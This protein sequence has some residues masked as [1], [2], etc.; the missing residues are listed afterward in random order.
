MRELKIELTPDNFKVWSEYCAQSTPGMNNLIDS[1]LESKKPFTT[2]LNDSVHSS[3]FGAGQ[4]E[5]VD[6]MRAEMVGILEQLGEDIEGVQEDFSSYGNLL[7]MSAVELDNNPGIQ[8]IKDLVEKLSN[9]T[10]STQKVTEDMGKSMGKL[11]EE[12]QRLSRELEEV[13]EEASKDPLTGL[14]N[15][16]SFDKTFAKLIADV[17][18]DSGFSLLMMDID[19]FKK[20]NDTYGHSTGDL[21]L[22][23]VASVLG[24]VTKGADLVTRYGGEEF[25]VL[26]PN[27]NCK[28]GVAL[29]ETIRTVIAKQKLF[30]GD[31]KQD[32]GNVTMSLGVSEYQPGDDSSSLLER[33]D[34]HL[35]RAKDAGRNTVCSDLA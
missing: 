30:K 2:K 9:D 28:G 31:Y 15:R 3:F 8:A 1:I 34:A 10:L 21:V 22:R 11:T 7:E 6:G 17:G 27:T 16:R 26:L 33:A 12:V 20:F 5:A 4:V 18:P 13:T 24:K 14:A 19:H 23:F 35:Y 32:I 29:A 25:S